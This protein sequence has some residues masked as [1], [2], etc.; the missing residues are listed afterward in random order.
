MKLVGRKTLELDCSLWHFQE[1]FEIHFE[2]C[3]SM[4]FLLGE[5]AC[6]N[7]VGRVPGERGQWSGE[8]L[9]SCCG[10]FASS[11]APSGR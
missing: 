10:V 8:A 2:F 11:R 7:G 3:H 6:E 1:R 5:K 4:K 9:S